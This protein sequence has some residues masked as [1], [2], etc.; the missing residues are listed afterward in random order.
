MRLGGRL[1]LRNEEGDDGTFI[2]GYASRTGVEYMVNGWTG[3]F[4][5]R[6][7]PGAFGESL[8]A[9]PD[10]HLL[11]NHAGLPLASTRSG[12]LELAEDDVGLRFSA[13]VDP[14]DPAVESI[15]RRI[16]RGIVSEASF[17]GWMLAGEE[18]ENGVMEISE[19][20]LERGDV[21]VVG[22]G[23]N[24]HTLLAARMALPP[25]MPP[26]QPGLPVVFESPVRDE[27]M[28][29]LRERLDYEALS[30]RETING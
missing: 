12:T 30:T 10:V 4:V 15:V 21:S 22:R 28:V 11:V 24:Q 26:H 1:E 29:R 5:E 6:V 3:Q 8:R 27:E 23:A 9:G 14:Q 20:D 13:E 2:A 16:K 25:W 17:G 18:D 19:I 7:R